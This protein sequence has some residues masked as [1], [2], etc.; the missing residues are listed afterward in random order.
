MVS[1]AGSEEEAARWRVG[2]GGEV[3]LLPAD[4]LEETGALGEDSERIRRGF[5]EETGSFRRGLV[6]LD[7]CLGRR[8]G[9]GSGRRGRRIVTIL[10]RREEE[11]ATG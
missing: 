6:G 3:G 2:V 9:V 5:G 4:P 8:G 7:W 1:C 11:G 10:G